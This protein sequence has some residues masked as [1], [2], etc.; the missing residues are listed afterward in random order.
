MA[1]PNVQL[2]SFWKG[3]HTFQELLANTIFFCFEIATIEQ[4]FRDIIYM[5]IGAL[6]FAKYLTLIRHKPI[7]IL[8]LKENLKY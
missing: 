7:L 4:N 1:Y 5:I 2:K 8:T 3:P 6:V